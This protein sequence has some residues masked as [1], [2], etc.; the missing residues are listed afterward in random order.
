MPGQ[1]PVMS[2]TNIIVASPCP[3]LLFPR[4]DL[5]SFLSFGGIS[6]QFSVARSRPRGQALSSQVQGLLE[7]RRAA[8]ETKA[9]SLDAYELACTNEA[10][11]M[12]WHFAAIFCPTQPPPW[13]GAFI[14]SPRPSGTPACCEENE[15]S[16]PCC[17]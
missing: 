4:E 7:R 10:S 15:D 17:I 11:L 6:Q 3:S 8:K 9:A 16:L 14:S 12:S 5:V 1:S 13:S 2:F